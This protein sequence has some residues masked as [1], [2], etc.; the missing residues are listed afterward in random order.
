MHPDFNRLLK[1]LWRETPDRVPNYEHLVDDKVMEAVL[2]EP[3]P[4]VGTTM[5][6]KERHV[7]YLVR[8]FKGLGYDYIP[9]E[10][11]M[12]LFRINIDISHSAEPLGKDSRGWVDNNRATIG[13]REE[14]DEYPWPEPGNAIDFEL[15]DAARDVLPAGMKLVS[16]VAGGVHEHV[17]WL[18]GIRQFSIALRRDP[19]FIAN[20]FQKIGTLIAGVDAIIA[21]RDHVGAM[22]MGDDM[23]YKAGTIL[24]PALLREH[25]FPWQKRAARIAHDHG[26]PFILH[27]CGNLGEVIDDL[28]DDVRIDAWHSFQDIIL[29]VTAAKERYGHRVAILGGVDV[30][31]LSRSTPD[32]VT[33][34]VIEIINSCKQGGGYALGSGN[35]IT[36]YIRIENYLA[37]LEAGRK[38]GAY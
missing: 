8:F 6:S 18:M 19:G 20:M 37:M 23:G 15:L 17:M 30:D 24:S 32:G 10:I 29:P 33:R 31:I 3:V 1:V 2:H 26:K 38:H 16:G 27:S 28:I 11:G 5:A 22:R 13:N 35:S 14:F 25:V 4:P 34:R 9:L 36:N 7:A 21:E 12:R